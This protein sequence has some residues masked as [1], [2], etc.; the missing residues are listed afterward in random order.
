[1]RV[2]AKLTAIASP[3]R[4][5]IIAALAGGPLHV[6]ELAGRSACRAP[7]ST[8]TFSDSKTPGT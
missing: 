3:Q 7:C 2:V 1:M 5:R 4:F 8:C 6:S